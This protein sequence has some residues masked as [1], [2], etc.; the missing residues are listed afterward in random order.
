MTSQ[1]PEYKTYLPRNVLIAKH[2]STPL[3]H[4][5]PS[6]VHVDRQLTSFVSNIYM[7]DRVS[8]AHWQ[9]CGSSVTGYV[10][11]G[12]LCN[13]SLHINAYARQ[14]IFIICRQDDESFRLRELFSCLGLVGCV[15]RAIYV[16]IWNDLWKVQV[17]R[18]QM[19]LIFSCLYFIFFRYNLCVI[20][21]YSCKVR[22]N[23]NYYWRKYWSKMKI[24]SI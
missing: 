24:N 20:L 23:T 17:D 12:T 21:W 3:W 16:L 22:L 8:I 9:L 13:F 19:S 5:D 10:H 4:F 7:S 1:F 18:N 2:L 6:K 15:V 14:A 11:T